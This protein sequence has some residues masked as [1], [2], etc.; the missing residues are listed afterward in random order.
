M[1]C[2]RGVLKGGVARVRDKAPF[3]LEN[4]LGSWLQLPRD[5][6]GRGYV[7]LFSPLTHVL[8]VFGAGFGSGRFVPRSVEEFFG[9]AGRGG[10]KVC[11]AQ[12]GGLL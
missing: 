11:F 6:G 3:E 4:L 9:V 10:G 1:N 2:M 12:Y 8:V 7:R 5:F